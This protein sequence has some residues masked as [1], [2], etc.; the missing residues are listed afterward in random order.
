VLVEVACAGLCRTDL[1]VADGSIS[2][3]EPRV[4][5]HEL[6]GTV[7]AAGVG[8]EALLGARVTADPRIDGGF[9]GLDRDGAFAEQ[10][11]L[12]ASAVHR[13]PD[14]LGWLAGA[15]VEPIAAALA[16]LD[17][18]PPLERQGLLLGRGRIAR[19]TELILRDAGARQL[20]RAERPIDAEP[21]E[22]ACDWAVETDGTSEGIAAA[23][24]ALRPGGLL[25]LKSRPAAPLLVDTAQVVRRGLR[26]QGVGWAPFEQALSLAERLPLEGLLGDV[27]P[28]ERFEEAFA[29]ARSDKEPKLFLAPQR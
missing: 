22:A 23:L 3:D 10:V 21:L 8:A 25:V 7:V 24:A 15:F 12:P 4:L 26:L 5:G 27:L 14:A 9:L 17:A 18:A 1:S 16:V 28:L 11:R 13:L 2:V 19:L 20:E 29:R 6:S